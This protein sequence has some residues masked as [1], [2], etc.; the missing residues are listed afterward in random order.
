MFHTVFQSSG[1]FWLFLNIK[2]VLQ[3]ILLAL[4]PQFLWPGKTATLSPSTL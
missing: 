1:I 3:E 4:Q 2:N